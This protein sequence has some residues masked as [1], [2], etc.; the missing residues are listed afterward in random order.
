MNPKKDFYFDT[1]LNEDD[2]R[3]FYSAAIVLLFLSL[4]ISHLFTRN[5]LWKMLGTESI[6]DI[7]SRIER[8]KVY[9][10]L[11]EQDFKDK[12]K[13]DQIKAL[14]E[15]D[16]A[17]T[18]GITEKE[19]FHSLSPFYEFILGNNSP[20]TNPKSSQPNSKEKEED[21]YE[22]GIFKS[23]PIIQKN[24]VL[25]PRKEIAPSTGSPQKIPS[26]YRFQQD[27]LFRWDGSQSISIPRKQLAGYQYFK[28][29]L[30]KIENSFYPPG[31]GN[32][33]YRDA[34][35][36]VIREGIAPGETKVVFLLNDAGDV[37]DVKQMSTQG[38]AIVDQACMDAIRGQNFGPVPPE[39]KQNGLTFGINFIFP[40]FRM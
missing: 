4:I 30:R 6:V 2:R 31:G 22:V 32:F 9:N 37:I 10:V 1:D 26:N 33:A 19:G 16:S 39:V 14:S 11:V 28:S 40:G 27:F 29:M 38:Q 21:V 25:Q 24:P 5:L 23:D 12:T 35:G 17:G 18:G 34:A 7:E 36:L 15:E 3:L 8:E 20:N 13:T